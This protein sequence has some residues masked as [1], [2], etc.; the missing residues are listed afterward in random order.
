MS[1]Q[2]IA[3]FDFPD[4]EY[5]ERLIPRSLREVSSPNPSPTTAAVGRAIAA[6]GPIPGGSTS[7]WKNLRTTLIV[8]IVLLAIALSAF[9]GEDMSISSGWQGLAVAFFVLVLVVAAGR[10]IRVIRSSTW[11]ARR[12]RTASENGWIEYY[13]ALLSEIWKTGRH[14]PHVDPTE[15]YYKAK[16]RIFLPDGTVQE[17]ISDEFESH[18]SP[19][20]FREQG[21]AVVRFQSQATFEHPTGWYIAAH[22]STMP[23]RYAS[24]H[25]QLSKE[26]VIAALN[27]A[28]SARF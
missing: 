28:A 16:V 27:A 1:Q 13:P 26:Q 12:L 6:A 22:L 7:G 19:R 3:P 18:T 17:I 23:L 11:G 10:N 2:A 24:L 9:I 8:A 20:A 21:V 4:H 14:V 25:H 5:S 15:Y